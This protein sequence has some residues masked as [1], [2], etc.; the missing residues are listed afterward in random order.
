[1]CLSFIYSMSH[2]MAQAFYPPP[3]EPRPCCIAAQTFVNS[4]GLPSVGWFTWTCSSQDA[5]PTCHHAAGELLPHLLT[6]SVPRDSCCFLLHYSTLTDCFYIRKWD[7]L[8]CPDFPLSTPW[9]RQR[10]TV[11]LLSNGKGTEKSPIRTAHHHKMHR[12]LSFFVRMCW[13]FAYII[14]R[15][16]QCWEWAGISEKQKKD[17]RPRDHETARPFEIAR[18]SRKRPPLFL[19]FLS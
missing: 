9:S 8:C 11:R 18:G 2:P 3:Y 5:Q 10:Q 14:Y 17:A 7:A 1:M 4:G 6:I 19:F 13:F 12:L 16:S 15:F